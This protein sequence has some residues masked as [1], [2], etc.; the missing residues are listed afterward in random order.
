MRSSSMVPSS[1]SPRSN[2]RAGHLAENLDFAANAARL[3]HPAISSE[4]R[5][6]QGLC[7][8]DVSGVVGG[9]VVAELPHPGEQRQVRDTPKRQCRQVFESHAGA[10][11]VEPPGASRPAESR[12]DL[13]IYELRGDQPFP[14]QPAAHEI[15][16]GAVVREGRRQN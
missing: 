15:P 16:I 8:G 9:Q 10:P 4:N 3:P 2:P 6:A 12:D 7:K 5:T 13:E 14:S 1:P 11:V